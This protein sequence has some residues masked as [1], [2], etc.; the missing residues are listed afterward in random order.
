MFTTNPRPYQRPQHQGKN[1]VCRY[2][3]YKRWSEDMFAWTL[4][5]NNKFEK[6]EFKSKL[7]IIKRLFL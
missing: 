4:N 6:I 1:L 2:C 5:A 7:E 3:T